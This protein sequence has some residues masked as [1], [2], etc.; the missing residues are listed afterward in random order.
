MTDIASLVFSSLHEL[1]LMSEASIIRHLHPFGL[2]ELLICDS[3][4]ITHIFFESTAKSVLCG[5]PH[6]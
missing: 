4:L 2:E 3:I 1:Y 5:D 6:F